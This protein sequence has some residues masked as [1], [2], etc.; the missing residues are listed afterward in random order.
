MVKSVSEREFYCKKCGKDINL[1]QD[2]NWVV[3]CDCFS[4]EHSGILPENW[5]LNN[6][7]YICEKC[8]SEP[9]LVSVK[10]DGIQISCNCSDIKNVQYKGELKKEW[11]FSI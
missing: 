6:N 4:K 3:S 5:C 7:T 9:I 11:T 1:G 8:K 10:Y 2:N